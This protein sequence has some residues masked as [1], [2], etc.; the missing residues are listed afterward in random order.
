[1]N[2]LLGFILLFVILK[3]AYRAINFGVSFLLWGIFD[4]R[5][6]HWVIKHFKNSP[7]VDRKRVVAFVKE[8]GKPPEDFTAWEMVAAFGL[9]LSDSTV[10]EVLK[11]AQAFGDQGWEQK[12]NFDFFTVLEQTAQ[13]VW[14]KWRDQVAINLYQFGQKLAQLY[15]DKHWEERFLVRI[16]REVANEDAQRWDSFRRLYP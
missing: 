14:W 8:G 15:G 3:L 9:I 2:Y 12:Y 1:M 5:N 7:N 11:S 10:S 4:G 6:Q 16:E 13:S